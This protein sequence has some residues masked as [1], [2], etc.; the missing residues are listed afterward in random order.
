MIKLASDKSFNRGICPVMNI[1]GKT[2]T[3]PFELK[4]SNF[5]F[6]SAQGI[7]GPK[8]MMIMD[9]IGTQLIHMRYG[10]KSFSDR[11]PRPNEKLVKQDSGKYMSA[12]LLK[13]VQ[14]NLSQPNDCM[15]PEGWYSKEGRLAHIDKQHKRIKKPLTIVLNDGNLRKELP[16]LGKYSSKQ[17]ADMITQTSENVLWMNYPVC[18]YNG[19]YSEVFPFHNFGFNSR[20][21]TL[22]GINPSKVSKNKN[23]LEREYYI[24]FNTILGYAFMQNMISCY[25]DLLPGKFYEMSDYAQLYYRL[26]ILSY[27][28]N[29]KTGKIPK[30]PITIDEI[31]QRLVLKTKDTYTVR[32]VIRR[33][34]EELK[35]NHF[36]KDYSEDKLDRKYVYRY[37]RNSWKEITGEENTSETDLEIS[38]TD[39]VAIGDSYGV[40]SNISGTHPKNGL[41]PVE[42]CND[43]SI[44]L[45]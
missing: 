26:F 41:E 24:Q 15:I 33:I 38:G 42:I 30:N 28:P 39:L 37:T 23:V 17:I 2:V 18:I 12:K 31:R 19:K 29:K 10:N 13:Y 35:S 3:Y 9:I 20:L 21:F 1:K 25:M 14:E 34:L 5:R 45:I 36:I 11:I 27:F 8:Q 16:F 43:S 6:D 4:Y 40:L 44:K 7:L 32:G 22:V